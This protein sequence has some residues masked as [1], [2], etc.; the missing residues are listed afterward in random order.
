MWMDV[1]QEGD[2]EEPDALRSDD[3]DT[4]YDRNSEFRRNPFADE[5]PTERR[6]MLD[7]RDTRCGVWSWRPEFLQHFATPNAF[8]GVFIVTGVLNGACWSYFTSSISTMEKR[9]QISSETTG[10]LLAGSELMQVMISIALSYFVI[11]SK[12]MKFITLGASLWALSCYVLASHQMFFGSGKY[13]LSM[14]RLQNEEPSVTSGVDAG[15]ENNQTDRVMSSVQLCLR[16]VEYVN[17][18]DV[19]DCPLGEGSSFPVTFVLLSQ[20]LSGTGTMFFLSSGGPY[21]EDIVMPNQLPILFGITLSLRLIGPFL[22]YIFGSVFLRIFISTVSTPAITEYDPRWMG[23]WWLGWLVFA[24]LTTIAAVTLGIFPSQMAREVLKKRSM[25]T[26]TGPPLLSLNSA[27]LQ[28]NSAELKIANTLP[29]SHNFM[30]TF[31]VFFNN[32]LNLYITLSTIFHIFVGIGYWTF[33]PKFLEVVFHEPAAQASV[34]TACVTVTFNAAGLLIS[35]V[36][37]SKV[38]PGA[39]QVSFWNAMATVVQ[40]LVLI[41]ITQFGCDSGDLVFSRDSS[42]AVTAG[43]TVPGLTTP[44]AFS[45]TTMLTSTENLL[46][47]SDLTTESTEWSTTQMITTTTVR[48]KRL[49]YL[50]S[51][52]CSAGCDCKLGPM[53]PLC[54]E[55]SGR[56]FYSPCHAG[57]QSVN[58]DGNETVFND[59]SCVSEGAV[60][61]NGFCEGHG[62]CRAG[63]V[64]TLILTA[65]A[66]FLGGTVVIGKM[67]IFYR[68]MESEGRS[69]VIS[70]GILIVSIFAMIPGPIIFGTVVDSACHIWEQTCRGNFGHCWHYN[71]KILRYGFNLTA[72][73]FLL[74]GGIFDVLLWRKVKVK[75]VRLYDGEIDH[76][77]KPSAGQEFEDMPRARISSSAYT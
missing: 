27:A 58:Y 52:N 20:L 16:D 31:L 18:S 26:D 21:V 45:E 6:G 60:V 41:I 51:S 69:L 70:L 72:A 1:I 35:G 44:I 29:V 24:I 19:Y 50:H 59:C 3:E 33:F 39:E 68:S 32:N 63:L 13:A 36:A 7:E 43:V 62:G 4:V 2:Q 66:Q 77:P 17:K 55:S 61:K 42:T 40:I 67:L 11:K 56:T 48:N 15:L 57:C 12:R 25:T 73:G 30:K 37:I 75:D 71:N 14:T 47:G 49:V 10:A 65:I 9:L 74:C 22:G 54:D 8:I 64:T 76:I 28:F 38:L 53:M 34:M 46:N 23:A 5:V